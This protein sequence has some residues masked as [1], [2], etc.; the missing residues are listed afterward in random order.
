MNLS[1]ARVELRRTQKP[2]KAS[3]LQKY[4]RTDEPFLGITVPEIRRVSRL[5]RDLKLSE[6]IQLLHSRV[7]EERLLALLILV[8]IYQRGDGAVQKAIY[9]LYFDNMKYINN[10]DLVDSSAPCILGSYLFEK[11]K[12]PL[13]RLAKAKSLW[14]RRISIISTQHFIRNGEFSETILIAKM[15]LKDKEDLIHK[16]VGWM[17]REV[18]NRSLETEL[19]FLNE[20]SLV[21]PRTMLRY[22]IEK[23]PNERRLMYLKRPPVRIEC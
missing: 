11:S 2:A 8:S 21:M 22:A 14:Y 19:S 1:E 4:F 20:Y 5:C 18:G 15:L 6:V 16:A 23:F 3:F 17:L 7:H 13:Y 9:R 10:W 12:K